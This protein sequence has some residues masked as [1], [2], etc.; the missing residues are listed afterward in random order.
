MENYTSGSRRARCGTPERNRALASSIFSLV[1][2]MFGCKHGRRSAVGV[3]PAVQPRCARRAA[4]A[5]PAALR[6]KLTS[7]P[8]MLV[9]ASRGVGQS[10][11]AC[12]GPRNP[13]VPLLASRE[14]RHDAARGTSRRPG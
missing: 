6:Q 5:C 10:G 14:R 7:R 2:H 11:S 1:E 8:H 4:A 12:G 9:Q 3:P 13:Q